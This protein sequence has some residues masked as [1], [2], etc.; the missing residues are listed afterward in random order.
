MILFG[1]PS[2]GLRKASWVAPWKRQ[3]RNMAA[4]SEFI[5]TLRQDWDSRFEQGLGFQLMVVAG[6]QD[7]FVPPDSNLAPFPRQ[8][9][10]VVPGN[11]LSMVRAADSDAPS[12]R[13]LVSALSDAPAMR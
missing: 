5:K 12:V 1:T 11:H 9:R 4:G 8:C 2:T 6:E 3:L 13:L 10:Y 7:Q